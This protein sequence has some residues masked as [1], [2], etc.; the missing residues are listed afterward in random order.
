MAPKKKIWPPLKAN[1]S[2]KGFPPTTPFWGQYRTQKRG[3]K[4]IKILKFPKKEEA[5]LQ[6]GENTQDNS[7]IGGMASPQIS[8]ILESFPSPFFTFK[9]AKKKNNFGGGVP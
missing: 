4:N 6:K 1:N 5:W 2:L 3:Q 7:W 8:R 9:E